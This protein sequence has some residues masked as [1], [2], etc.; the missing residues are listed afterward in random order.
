MTT[1]DGPVKRSITIVGHRTSLSM[2]DEFW[3]ALKSLAAER[4]ISVAELITDIDKNRGSRNLSSAIRVFVLTEL[5]SKARV[6]V[7]TGHTDII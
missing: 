7:R 2:E 4:R 6:C 1:S 5:A 3:T